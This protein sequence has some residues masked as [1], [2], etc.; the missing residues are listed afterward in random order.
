M[1]LLFLHMV[2]DKIGRATKVHI[3][4]WCVFLQMFK[5]RGIKVIREKPGDV[6]LEC[7]HSC[8]S[9]SINGSDCCLRHGGAEMKI[10]SAASCRETIT[11]SIFT[12]NVKKKTALVGKRSFVRDFN[13]IPAPTMWPDSLPS[14]C[15]HTTSS[16][17]SQN[18]QC[19]KVKTFG[20]VV[21]LGLSDI[22]MSLKSSGDE[23]DRPLW[24]CKCPYKWYGCCE[25]FAAFTYRAEM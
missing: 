15:A 20:L 9:S 16:A 4:E 23:R 10:Q 22:L 17:C 19:D 2:Q 1:F 13:G 5:G 11:G 7:F 21:I 3:R 8:C 14:V 12:T 24:T 6:E 18:S 25:T